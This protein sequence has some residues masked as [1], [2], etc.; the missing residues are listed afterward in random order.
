MVD[1]SL[2]KILVSWDDYSQYM[3]SHKIHVPNHQ[4]A[5]CSLWKSAQSR[6]ESHPPLTARNASAS[7]GG[8]GEHWAWPPNRHLNDGRLHGL[9]LGVMGQ[10]VNQMMSSIAMWDILCLSGHTWYP[11]YIYILCVYI[12]IWAVIKRSSCSEG[13]K[14]MLMLQ[15]M[16]CSGLAYLQE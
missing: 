6:C 3:G 15:L 1:L 13:T 9:E 11:K 5:Y 2:W 14:E 8:S 10:W 7:P 16:R 4:P 12:C